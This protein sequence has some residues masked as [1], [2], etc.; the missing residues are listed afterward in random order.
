MK[1]SKVIKR[2]LRRALYP[3]RLWRAYIKQKRSK[4]TERVYN[5][6]QLQLY[7]KILKGD[8][9]HYGYFKNIDT[10]PETISINDIEEAQMNYAELFIDKISDK[11]NTVLDIGCGM[12]GLSALLKEKNLIPNALT[13]DKNQIGYIKN[14][15]P[16]IPV[17]EGKFEDINVSN[18]TDFYG[19]VITSESLQ[20]LDIE[21]S[22][23]IIDKIL[24]QGGRWLI[25]DYFKRGQSFEKSGHNWEYFSEVLKKN[26]WNISYKVDITDN[27][28]VTLKYIYML[29]TRIGSPLADFIFGKFKS[30]QPGFYYL[31]ED[32]ITSLEESLQ[33]NIEIINP[34]RF[35]EE[36]MYI[37]MVVER[38]EK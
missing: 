2:T 33:K 15:Y 17:I 36:K 28:L 23:D 12:G 1:L 29:G 13:P 5:D 7:S 25:C 16:G 30:K 26:G 11:E 18:Y 8:F 14:K 9:L 20:Y 32:I 34:D 22:V 37:F 10:K 4:R 3:A 38:L 31:T 6:A 19:T 24:K 27:V 35:K 21:K